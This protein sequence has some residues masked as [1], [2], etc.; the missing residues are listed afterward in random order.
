[1]IDSCTRSPDE[2][3]FTL[4]INGDRHTY[5]NDKEGKRQAILDSLNVIETITVAEDTYLPDDVALQ[6]VAV[7]MF[8]DGI[9]TE[10]AYE[11]VCRTAVK[12][13]THLGYGDEIQL[14]PPL[15]SFSQRGS[16]RKRYPAV[17][18]QWVLAEVDD[19]SLNRDKP[20][21]EIMAQ[22]VWSQVAWEVYG[23]SWHEL[24]PSQQDSLKQQVD[25]ITQEANWRQTL[26]GATPYYFLPLTPD[27]E[28]ARQEITAVLA[29]AE[30]API[31]HS[32]VAVR[33]QIAAYGHKFYEPQLAPE[34]EECL[35]QLLAEA[36]YGIQPKDGEYRPLPL[37]LPDNIGEQFQQLLPAIPQHQTQL[38]TAL[39]FQ[40]VVRV[41][42][43]I[44]DLPTL[45]DWQ[46]SQLMT[47]GVLGKVLRQAGYQAVLQWLQP[48]QFIPSLDDMYEQL[49]MLKEV[50]V[51][52][53]TKR[54][55]SLAKGLTVYTPAIVLD[56]DNDN[57]IYLEMVGHKQSVR[58]NWAA[59]V[60]KKVRWIGR[61]RVYL[62][63]MKEHVMIRSS[64]PCGWVDHILIHK[65]ASIR[66][67]NPEEPFFLLDDGCHA[68][69]PLFYPMLNKCLAVPVL[70]EWAGYLWENGRAHNLITLLNKGEG[71]GYAAWR[72]LPA[73]DEWQEVVQAGLK[74]RHICF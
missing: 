35:Q 63:G 34:L 45:S 17:A 43:E 70:E 26:R 71:Q 65:Q 7:I 55:L 58:A 74:D 18:P 60:G 24:T 10:K 33:T 57:I 39:L 68:I 9:Q 36:G 5:T 15:V 69:P 14:G 59:L 47:T 27:I 12:A 64:L 2:K 72:A 20:Q 67:M 51:Q 66:E 46:A 13:C 28:K 32:R 50:R 73:P 25:A 6:V 37:K 53:D 29:E 61:Q 3:T 23:Q 16:Y 30:G 4:S 21:K 22:T 44:P 11:M 1:M 38:G 31:Y 19:A 54:Q 8:P 41:L 62:D 40:D 49:V 42:Q 56:S 52:N 48:Y